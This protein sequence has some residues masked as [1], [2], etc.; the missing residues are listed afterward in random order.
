VQIKTDEVMAQLKELLSHNLKINLKP[1]PIRCSECNAPIRKVKAGEADLLKAKDY[2][3]VHMIGTWDFWIC[4]H[5][6]R[7]YWEGSHW[8]DMRERLQPLNELKRSGV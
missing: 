1:V 6:G 4:E 2:V 5:C 3:P 7:V 8:R